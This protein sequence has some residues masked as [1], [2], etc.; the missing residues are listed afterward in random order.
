MEVLRLSDITRFAWYDA[1]SC[2][3]T[4]GHSQE[5]DWSCFLSNDAIFFGNELKTGHKYDDLA[6][7]VKIRS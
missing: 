5:I 3:L 2:V 7:G 4:L 1:V 6:L